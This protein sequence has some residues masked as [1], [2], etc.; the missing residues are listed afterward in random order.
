[1]LSAL[2]LAALPLATHAADA[3]PDIVEL[4]KRNTHSLAYTDTAISGPGAD[5]LLA[6]TADARSCCLARTISITRSRVSPALCST[7]HDQRGYHPGGGAGPGGHRG[8]ARDRATVTPARSP[9]TPGHTRRCTNSTPTRT[10]PMLALA[11]RLEK[12]PDDLGHRTI[13]R[14][15]ALSG[16]L[17]KLAP[18]AV[19]ARVGKMLAE[20]RR[21]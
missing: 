8:L 18:N 19:R 9:R 21:R 2:Q 1:M 12:G 5:H 20:A 3:P 11:G 10:S 14:R 7:L 4:A 13:H 15:G 16:G 17:S 6:A